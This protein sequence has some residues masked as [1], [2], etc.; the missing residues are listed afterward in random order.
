MCPRSPSHYLSEQ[1]D[2]RG[3]FIRVQ[4]QLEDARLGAFLLGGQDSAGS[5][6]QDF[7]LRVVER[8]F[9]RVHPAPGRFRDYLKRS[10]RNAAL[11]FLRRRRPQTHHETVLVGAVVSDDA[12]R[13]AE[14]QW[15]M[16]WRTCV[17]DSAW[18]ALDVHQRRSPGNLFHTVLRLVSDYP[19]EASQELARRATE[20]TGQPLSP[21]AFRKQFSRA[22]RMF[23]EL[24]VREIA[25]TLDRVTAE[26][27]EEELGELR[28]LRLVL[29]WLPSDWRSRLLV[30]SPA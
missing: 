29:A 2:P 3:E 8:G 26:L 15:Q 16:Q 30:S 1:G 19:G 18:R 10:V 22:R 9:D 14:R 21:E 24:I 20:Q 23:A 7:L 25:D 12:I 27:V 5:P 17:L 11:N 28:L 13:Q 4:L 6:S